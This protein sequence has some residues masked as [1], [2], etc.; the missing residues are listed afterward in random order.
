[1]GEVLKIDSIKEFKLQQ[2]VMSH[3][4]KLVLNNISLAPYHYKNQPPFFL[5]FKRCIE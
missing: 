4:D 2:Q 5:I 3:M 1:M